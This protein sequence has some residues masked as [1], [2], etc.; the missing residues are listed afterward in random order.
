L[1]SPPKESAGTSTVEEYLRFHAQLRLS[2]NADSEAIKMAVARL[3]H[4]FGLERCAKSLIGDAS[5]RG[6]SGGE[7]RRLSIAAELLTRP[8]ILLIDEA[9]TGL[10]ATSAKRV[11]TILQHLSHTGITVI[12]SVHQPRADIFAAMTHL[13]L[14]SSHAEFGGRVVFSGH[15]AAAEPYF[16]NQ[17][18]ECP[19]GV[20]IADYML[21]VVV[22]SPH[23]EVEQLV[24][25]FQSSDESK[26][27][28]QPSADA[29]DTEA[30][31]IEKFKPTLILQVC[32]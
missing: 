9:T 10:D 28:G 21:D 27:L 7:Q 6:I 15:A 20:N 30:D 18:R 23:D 26:S 31:W 1:I 22:A 8:P 16:A 3:L 13:L 25:A 5:L 24:Q 17:G 32:W 4:K 29:Q 19:M 12:M 11:V 2:S 14:M